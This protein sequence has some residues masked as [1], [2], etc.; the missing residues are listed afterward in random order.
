MLIV[1]F[2]STCSF[3]GQVSDKIPFLKLASISSSLTSP[4]KKDLVTFTVALSFTVKIFLF[5]SSSSFFRMLQLILL[6]LLK[7]LY[8]LFVAWCFHFNA[9]FSIFFIYI[10]FDIFFSFKETIIKKTIY[11][12]TYKPLSFL[13][14][15]LP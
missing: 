1:F 6:Y 9:Y 10:T 15:C 14:I 4:K 2:V 7:W 5:S 13:F 11:L 3:L 8:R 12:A